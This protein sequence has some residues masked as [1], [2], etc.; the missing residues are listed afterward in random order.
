MV[1]KSHTAKRVLRIMTRYLYDFDSDFL[2]TSIS[3]ANFLRMF[4][5]LILQRGRRIFFVF[6]PFYVRIRTRFGSERLGRLEINI[7][8]ICDVV[9]QL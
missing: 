8:T 9:L 3:G 4:I 6:R 5:E 7:N 1:I 2:A